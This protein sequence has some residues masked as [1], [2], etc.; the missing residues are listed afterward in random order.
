[1][2]S[3]PPNQNGS[4]SPDPISSEPPHQAG[5]VIS[6][7]AQPANNI[8]AI[9]P[10]FKSLPPLTTTVPNTSLSD[11]PAP[12][13]TP[14]PLV[15]G[16]SM[17]EQAGTS[18]RS[19]RFGFP[20]VPKK[21]RILLI[22]LLILGGGSAGAYFGYFVPNKPENVWRTALINSGKGYDKLSQYATSK[23]N[24]KGMSAKGSFKFSGSV[25]ADGT[26]N[27][28]SDGK[29]GQLTG[30]VSA[31]GLKINYDV[32]AIDSAGNTPDIYFKIDGIQGLGS[33]VGGYV[34]E[35]AKNQIAKA[36]NGLNGQWYFVDHTLFDQFA[37]S[38]NSSLQ[39]NSGDV[40]QVL[41]AVGDASKQYLFTNNNEKM[42]IV[43]KQYVGKE[44][45]DGNTVYHYKVGVNKTN[46]EA[47][48]KALCNNLAKTKLFKLFGGH[49]GAGDVDLIQNCKDATGIDKIDD[50]RTA[51]AWVDLHTKL[52]HKIR[53]TEKGNSNNYTEIAQNYKGGDEI[54]FSIGVHEQESVD[55]GIDTQSK[56]KPTTTT[57]LINMK[58]N[59][60]TN[61]FTLNANFE[62]TGDTND[63]G[64][65]NLTVAP[66]NATAKVDKPAGAKTI[67]EL[68]NDLGLSDLTADTGSPGS[69][70]SS[71][72]DA[73]RKT[74][75]N[76]LE[77]ELEVYYTDQGSYPTLAQLNSA[78]WRKIN[79]PS[80]DDTILK[81]PAGTQASLVSS[82]KAKVFAY[83]PTP[84]N[85]NGSNCMSYILTATLDDGTIYKKQSLSQ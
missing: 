75:I 49:V 20:R 42:A 22:A 6:P 5:E 76:A 21:I 60:K 41:K 19:R 38:S 13:L 40:D 31:V 8:Q 80:F 83:Q 64:T 30:S 37:Q 45:Q 51:D 9:E 34:D 29:N 59:T 57:G 32:R 85:C 28:L 10:E 82:P 3:Q 68:L 71:S 73:Q 25:A 27:G 74:D 52:I 26:F 62:D 2:E 70:Q 67:I 53:F 11:S 17:Q 14:Q 61:T 65:F 33:L 55:S 18:S 72:K 24:V 7:N 43:V 12:S 63:K 1:M 39:F 77:T 81:D 44:K 23:K 46:L 16:S 36:L 4:P 69:T 78:S 50:T 84:A 15:S 66:S 58:L 35:S 56:S 47:Y 79:M 54:P 48:N